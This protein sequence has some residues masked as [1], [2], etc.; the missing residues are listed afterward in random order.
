MKLRFLLLT[1]TL[2]AFLSVSVSG[3]L[4]YSSLRDSAYIEAEQNA[5]ARVNAIHR[6]LLAFFSESIRPVK[7]MAGMSPLVQALI[8]K[9][10]DSRRGADTILDY[11][12][13]SL[14]SSVCYLMDWE[15]LTVATSNRNDPDSFFGENFSFRPY[16]RQ[17]IE[18][19]P[20][21]Y[22]ALGATSNLRGAYYS[23]PVYSPDEV[24]PIGVAV[25]KVSIDSIEEEIGLM[26]DGM[27][28]ITDPDGVIFISNK[29]ELL[30]HLVWQ[31]PDSDVD[32]IRQTR[33]FGDGPFPWAGFRRIDGR[34]AQD[35]RNVVYQF[36]ERE[37]H[38]YQGWRILY[39]KDLK[40]IARSVSDPLIQI[41]GR[42]GV[43]LLLLIGG[44]VL[45]L[46]GRAS[47]EIHRRKEAEQ[48]LT[49]S[50]RRYRYL[51]HHTP[52][53]LHSIDS[54][55]VLISVSDYWLEVLG[56]SREEVIGRRVSEFYTPE[57]RNT[58]EQI[59]IPQFFRTGFCKD[60]PY[61]YVK[62]NGEVIDV[63]LSAIAE[64][65]ERGV[66]VR[67]L[68]V[69]INITERKEAEQALIQARD[70]LKRYSRKLEI[71]MA[72]RTREISGI[73]QYT[74]DCI[75]LKDRDNRYRLVNSRFEALWGLVNRDVVGCT[76][77]DI[78]PEVIARRMSEV[79]RRILETGRSIQVE[80]TVPGPDGEMVFLSVKFPLYDGSGSVSG[81]CGI[82]TDITAIKQM[83]DQFRRLSAAIMEGQ[84][85]ER[86]AIA[87]ELHDEL[88]QVLTALR[89]DAVWMRDRLA[90]H[91][92]NASERAAGMC[93]LI[94]KNIQDIRGIALRLRPRVLDDLGLVDA[95][96][97][98]TADFER[99]T[100]IACIFDP[101]DV[102]GLEERLATAAYRIVQEALTNVA[103]HSDAT[104]A[105]VALSRDGDWLN[106]TI[107][108][109]GCGFQA[110]NLHLIQ[111]LGIAGMKERASLAGGS[112]EVFSSA[113][114]GTQVV[115]R[116]PMQ[117]KKGEMH[118]Q[119]PVGG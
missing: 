63:L 119:G 102:R 25:I 114:E 13:A 109:D 31:L 17:A 4:Y 72:G 40:S 47:R 107:R 18:G 53:M 104:F 113:A 66:I 87:R 116:A 101:G 51:Y 20:G 69:S 103:R 89:M 32:R 23:H 64:R 71:E 48:A 30:L 78:L 94:D 73:L 76:D 98:F 7:I 42:I 58:A 52:A 26:D 83:Q 39:L 74:P 3:Y 2:L 67:S 65:D 79:D 84:E 24:N 111:G 56:Y 80:E 90:A 10:P 16:F 41:S 61:R 12:N 99:R 106:L 92:P 11:F 35:S 1:L 62:K 28:L 97:W 108:D 19:A 15:G 85:K 100:G 59:V 81:V 54:A 34:H 105:E 115:F 118:D 21:A 57:S 91:D 22:L 55:G 6:N 95:L 88:G 93:V 50:M 43:W 38:S 68:S 75:Y 86:A 110:E 70:D 49:E 8:Q 37:L 117:T 29:K 96:E 9:D 46:Y 112:L 33:Q 36:Y 27:V 60:V 82:L 14:G 77:E 44:S 45:F 5:A